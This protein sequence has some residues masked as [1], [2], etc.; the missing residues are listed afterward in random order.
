M[1][2]QGY[3]TTV[4][5]SDDSGST[6]STVGGMTSAAINI[7]RTSLDVTEFGDDAMD[8]IVGLFDNPVP[9]SGHYDASDA[10][11]DIIRA[12]LFSGNTVKMRVLF[13]GTNGYTVDVKVTGEETST[14]PDGTVE[15]SYTLE[16]IDKPTAVS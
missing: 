6:Y 16:S 14:S 10:G 12:A 11:Q 3:N 5:A 2:T 8:R 7:S 1:A 9:L 13:D 4:E 15:T